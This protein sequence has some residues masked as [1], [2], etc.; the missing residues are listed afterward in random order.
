MT[1]NKPFGSVI[2]IVSAGRGASVN[3]V[4]ILGRILSG[5]QCTLTQALILN[6]VSIEMLEKKEGNAKIKTTFL[7]VSS[8]K[9]FY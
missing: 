9:R 6:H 7:T 4:Y 8:S 1:P 2:Y 5:R 3:E